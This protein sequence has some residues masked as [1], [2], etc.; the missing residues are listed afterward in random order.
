M[1]DTDSDMD[2]PVTSDQIQKQ[3]LKLFQKKVKK[4]EQEFNNL[5][6]KPVPDKIDFSLDISV[7]KPDEAEMVARFN[8]AL[9]L[10]TQDLN[11][12]FPEKKKK[13]GSK[14]IN[15]DISDAADISI[16]ASDISVNASDINAA[17]INAIDSVNSLNASKKEKRSKLNNNNAS[18]HV[19]FTIDPIEPIESKE[20]N[21]DIPTP[22]NNNKNSGLLSRLSFANIS[23]ANTGVAN[24]SPANTGV[25]NTGVANTSSVDGS[26]PISNSEFLLK[27]KQKYVKKNIEEDIPTQFNAD[28]AISINKIDNDKMNNDK[29]NNNNNTDEIKRLMNEIIKNQNKI[30]QLI[31][32]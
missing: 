14:W 11:I 5:I 18:N 29:M 16:N 24:I 31:N 9:L 32:E 13:E 7:E 10:R 26:I 28:A 23:P 12:S 4:N 27:M 1:S 25:A 21:I 8:N 3:N 22:K 30:I 20:K 17:D 15:S 6:K 19:S 2:E